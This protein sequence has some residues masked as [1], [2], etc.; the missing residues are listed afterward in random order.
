[1]LDKFTGILRNR[2]L[3]DS[4]FI[5]FANLFG[6]GVNF[7]IGVKVANFL[8]PD[9]LGDLSFANSIVGIFIVLST[10][11]LD[12][13]VVRELVKGE[14]KTG[15]LLGTSFGL[16]FTGGIFMLSLLI[17]VGSSTVDERLIVHAILLIGS[18]VVFNSLNCVDFLFKAKSKN[19]YPSVA[20][21]LAV[22]VTSVYKLYLVS[23]T[24]ED[25]RYFALAY[26][27]DAM[28]V[29]TMLVVFYFKGS[30]GSIFGWKF[31]MT[32]AKRLLRNSLPLI[33][34]GLVISVYMKIDLVMIKSMLTSF[35]AG[36]YAVAVRMS[37][38]WYMIPVA[39][40]TS[41]FPSIIRAKDDRET[42]DKLFTKLTSRLASLALILSVLVTF[43][44]PVIM[45]ILFNEEYDHSVDVL[46]IHIWASLFIF[47]G[48]PARKSV[49]VFNLQKYTLMVTAIAA[50]VNV[51]LNYWL[52]EAWGISGAAFSTVISY[53]LGSFL[54]YGCFKPTQAIFLLQ[55]KS[56]LL[57]S[58]TKQ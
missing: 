28:I 10:L 14:Y 15:E 30:I 29:V 32:L 37:E 12:N 22:V 40:S 35:D 16:K 17:A 26:S 49:V 4:M 11:G 39:I 18:S 58:F 25:I 1:M 48:Q 50:L 23:E 27:L 57:G 7:F 51:I 44:A 34:T 52:I 43:L 56:L 19:F 41:Y 54:L 13:I 46:K 8:G 2:L 6:Q 21:M 53:A 5:M 55:V 24:V 38:I 42:F 45:R 47:I 9:S 31:K 33:L 36:Q 3:G 20:R